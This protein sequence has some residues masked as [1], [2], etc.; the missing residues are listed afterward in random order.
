MAYCEGVWPGTGDPLEFL[1]WLLHTLHVALGG[2]KREGSSEVH[3]IFQGAMRI[4]TRKL[5]PASEVGVAMSVV[6]IEMVVLQSTG[7]V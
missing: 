3:R 7:H 4:S 6:A 5:P 1:L 2:T